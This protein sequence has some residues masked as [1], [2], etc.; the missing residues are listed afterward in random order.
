MRRRL[1]E[2][3]PKRPARISLAKI[4]E[5]FHER[6]LREKSEKI[7]RMWA[8]SPQGAFEECR[9]VLEHYV[10]VTR[11]PS[12]V[13]ERYWKDRHLISSVC[14]QLAKHQPPQALRMANEFLRQFPENERQSIVPQELLK[15]REALSRK[16]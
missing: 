2:S 8:E 4:E 1:A 14:R 3:R 12:L 9:S 16:R 10:P 7:E 15:L 13:V 11:D 5:A 6:L